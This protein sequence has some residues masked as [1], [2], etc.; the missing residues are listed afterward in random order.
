MIKKQIKKFLIKNRWQLKKISIPNTYTNEPPT[1]EEVNI[2]HK[3]KG[4]FHL[5][6][7][8]GG[9]AEIYDWFQKKVIWIEANPKI[10][11]DLEIKIMQFINQSAYNYLISDKN[12]DNVK[13][14]LSNNDQAS[15]SIFNF[16][17]LSSGKKSL[18][19]DK[20]LQMTESINLP[21]ISIDH[22][23]K[24]EKI[25]IKNF[26]HWVLDLQGAELLA[27]K[28]GI[29]SLEDCNS[30]LIEVSTGDVYKNG[31]KWDDIKDYLNKKNFKECW[32]PKEI[33]S[34]V[35]FVK[36]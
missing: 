19:G 14:N 13:F 17:D 1:Q 5:G 2:L 32:S 34:S 36:Y 9:E 29:K 25:D 12:D 26:D 18:W 35:L 24:K 33:H 3:C 30:I 27:L 6:A 10:F 21:S 11:E 7:H 22:F 31:A 4:I 20:N 8:R 23:V 16:G 15:S 28:G